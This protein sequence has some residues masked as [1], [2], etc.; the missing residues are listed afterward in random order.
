MRA[1]PVVAITGPKRGGIARFFIS[2]AVWLAGG[3]P[4]L[5]LTG[6]EH[7]DRAFDALIISGGNDLEH[8]LYESP[9]CDLE[10]VITAERDALEYALLHKA[11]DLNLPVFGI[12]RG[13][14][15]IN[16]YFGGSLD[17]DITVRFGS[18]RYSVLPWKRIALHRSSFLYQNFERRRISINTLHHQAVEE[19][20]SGFFVAAIDSNGMVQAIEHENLPVYGVQ[21]HPEYL[22][23]RAAHRRLFKNFIGL[24]QSCNAA[25]GMHGNAGT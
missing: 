20:A 19:A 9:F 5:F 17:K 16:V 21:W 8:Q 2:L 10:D 7:N 6:K 13:Y 11:L 12:C 24:A 18:I 14:Q 15:L 23:W 1:R 25:S 22:I 3:R 4:K